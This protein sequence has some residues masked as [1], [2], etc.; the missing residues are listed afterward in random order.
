VGISVSRV[1]GNAQI[2]SMKKVAG[3]LKLDQAQ[4]R[5][6]EAFAKFGSDMDAATLSVLNKGA[7]NVEILK[8]GQ[9]SPYS[10]ERQVAILYCGSQGLLRSVPV[11]KTKEF[12]KDFL[13]MMELKH[14]DVLAELATG[15]YTDQ[16]Q[17]TMR[18]VAAEVSEKY[19]N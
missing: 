6:L 13:D 19:K 7:K 2:K 1:G 17:D 15:K 14:K 5:E 11:E 10:V 12:E 18:Q 9:Y 16:A 4:Y 8:Q 3:T